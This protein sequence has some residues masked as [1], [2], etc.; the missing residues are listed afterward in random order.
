MNLR[1]IHTI[2]IMLGCHRSRTVTLS[3]C[4]YRSIFL[5]CFR[6]RKIPHHNS[7]TSRCYFFHPK[8][9]K[10]ITQP[11]S[12][13]KE[14]SI[15]VSCF[16]PLKTE[17]RSKDRALYRSVTFFTLKGWKVLQNCAVTI[18]YSIAVSLFSPKKCG[19]RYET[20]QCTDITLPI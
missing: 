1:L 17:L 6:D 15:M 2:Y 19:K 12:R 8:R 5:H 18:K 20:L 16:S 4:P 9:V 7:T 3:R 13:Q 14:H 10:R 11:R